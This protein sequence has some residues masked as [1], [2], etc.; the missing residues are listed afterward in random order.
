MRID[1][2]L[3]IPKDVADQIAAF[4]VPDGT[5]FLT[6]AYPFPLTAELLNGALYLRAAT[7][8]EVTALLTTGLPP[9][10]GIDWPG[11]PALAAGREVEWQ[12]NAN[13][14]P[15]F[16]D[17]CRLWAGEVLLSSGKGVAGPFYIHE[18]AARAWAFS[19]ALKRPESE[20]FEVQVVAYVGA[21][22]SRPRCYGRASWHIVAIA[23]AR[24]CRRLRPG[25]APTGS[26]LPDGSPG[27]WSSMDKGRGCWTATGT[28]PASAQERGL[29]MT[30]RCLRFRPHRPQ[31]L[32]HLARP[33]GLAEKVAVLLDRSVQG[34]QVSSKLLV[35]GH[36]PGAPAGLHAPVPVRQRGHLHGVMR[37]DEGVDGALSIMP[38]CVEEIDSKGLV[39]LLGHVRG[40]A[41]P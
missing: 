32:L 17:G 20:V 16:E 6:D 34:R 2:R 39:G 18:L 5:A 27:A 4:D 35:D 37:P 38:G 26:P 10:E 36:R 31:M 11:D 1:P 24:P 13:D 30:T 21:R 25:G 19:E 40:S 15:S 3:A 29:P 23:V 33:D 28:A 41:R 12:C 22:P 9:E 8:D 14:V 7:G